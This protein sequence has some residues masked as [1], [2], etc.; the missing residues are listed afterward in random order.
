MRLGVAP[1]PTK[2]PSE[3]PSPAK[4]IS[5]RTISAEAIAS[6]KRWVC[7]RDSILKGKRLH[8]V[9]PE[10]FPVILSYNAAVT[11]RPRYVSVLPP[12]VANQTTSMTSGSC[13][14]STTDERFASKNPNW[15][16]R[17]ESYLPRALND[18]ARFIPVNARN[19]AS[20]DFNS[21]MPFSSRPHSRSNSS[22]ALVACCCISVD[23]PSA[24]PRCSSTSAA[25]LAL[26]QLLSAESRASAGP[27]G[28]AAESMNRMVGIGSSTLQYRGLWRSTVTAS[29][30]T[31]APASVRTPQLMPYASI[32]LSYLNESSSASSMKGSVS[33]FSTRNSDW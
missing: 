13:S 16:G 22:A 26:P 5:R 7:C 27:I 4:P 2:N 23:H 30:V 17:Q 15:N 14:L 1:C 28:S 33:R 20:S 3:K 31:M 29:S 21:S 25:Q 6:A 12:P 10:T 8:A 9:I 18:I 24:P 11:K 19:K 32:H